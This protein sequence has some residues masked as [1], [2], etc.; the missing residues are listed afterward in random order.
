MQDRSSVIAIVVILAI[1]CL[2]AYVAVTGYLNARPPDAPDATPGVQATP[3]VINLQTDVPAATKPPVAIANTATPLPVPSPLGALR[4]I[5]AAVKV[6]APPATIRPT[7]VPATATPAS[8]AMPG[9]AGM[10]FCAQGGAPDASIAP[11]GAECP[12]NY[13]WGRVVDNL[14]KGIPGRK[15]AFT[16]PIGTNVTVETK[17]PPDSPGA[18]NI[19]APSGAWIVWLVDGSG[20]R[21]SPQVTVNMHASFLGG[22]ICPSRVDFVQQK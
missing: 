18:Y 5:T 14:G 4:T 16:D 1:C 20:N 9:C 10:A 2:G 7:S 21:V 15:V 3:L 11:T 8:A 12:R 6:Q 22:T 19:P 17:G 13:V